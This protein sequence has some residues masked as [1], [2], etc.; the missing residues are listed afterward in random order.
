MNCTQSKLTEMLAWYHQFCVKYGLRYYVVGGTCL[1]AVRHQGFIP[2]DDDIDVGMPRED[3]N[4]FAEYMQ[5]EAEHTGPYLLEMPFEKK[6]FVYPYAKLYD[7]STTLVENTRYKT[8]RGIYIDVFPLDGAGDTEEESLITFKKIDKKTNYLCT[9]V[10]ALSSHRKFY[11]NAAIVLARCIPEFLFGWRKTM[12]N[13]IRL[14]SQ[15]PFDDCE[16]I[17]N[18]SGNWH[19]KEIMRR[20]WLGEPKLYAF[21]NIQVYGPADADSYLRKLYGDYMKLPP[22]EKQVSHHDYLYQNLE[23]SYLE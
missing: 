17:A 5:K 9:K 19:E 23:K 18:F 8:K 22:K 20:E 12:K 1:G 14:S 11:K 7:T 21:E 4:K 3:Y 2:W 10:C 16:Y 13:I 6:D 15:K